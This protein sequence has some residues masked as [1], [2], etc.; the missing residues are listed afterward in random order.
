MSEKKIKRNSSI[1]LLK[2]LAIFIIVFSHAMP[3]GDLGQCK[4]YNSA[5][6][7]SV[8]TN[9]I[10]FIILG[11]V[12]NMGQIGN[13]IFL[14]CSAWFLIESE[15]TKLNK[16]VQMV[17]S[18]F[19]ISVLMLILFTFLGYRFGITYYIKQFL[20][21]TFA[22]SWFL[23]CYLL[24]YSIH[25]LLNII[26]N[27]IEQKKLL[28]I[29]CMFVLLYCIESF[30][31]EERLFFYSDFIGFCGIYFLVAYM[32]K[33]MAYAHNR[34]KIGILACLIGIIGWLVQN[35]VTNYMGL[36]F[37]LFSDKVQLWNKFINPCYILIAI[38]LFITFKNYKFYSKIIN[39]I[40]SLSL[41]VYM[42][43]CNRIVRDYF[44][45][46][47]FDFIKNN[48]TYKHILFWTSIYGVVSLILGIIL[49][50]VY[51]KTLKIIVNKIG[52]K[53]TG[54]LLSNWNKICFKI[55]M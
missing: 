15:S 23:T 34:L 45:F 55:N 19:C 17:L 35:L 21:V 10:Q 22:N 29:V 54:I 9:N 48:Y 53:F 26:I 52:S 3:D 13:D 30:I 27:K 16:I 31:L 14:I 11:F 50:I 47:F 38:G 20:P 36:Y 5:I 40:S 25:P 8:A 2:I 6:N 39:Y 12:H 51:D 33:Y 42:I 37:N 44:R 32:K 49:S 7:L 41:L 4:S 46:D 1:E 28:L 18:C 43:H 24:L